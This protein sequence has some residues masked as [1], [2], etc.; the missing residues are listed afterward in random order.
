MCLVS[1]TGFPPFNKTAEQETI[2][3]LDSSMEPLRALTPKAG[4]YLNE[5]R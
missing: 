4:A 2:K 5:V 1:A 3:L